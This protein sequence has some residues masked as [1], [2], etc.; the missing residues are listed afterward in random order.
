MILLQRQFEVHLFTITLLSRAHPPSAFDDMHTLINK[1]GSL[2]HR[3]V[4]KL[5]ADVQMVLLCLSAP[6]L[7]KLS[8]AS[9]LLFDQ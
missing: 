7:F 3:M 5:L 1:Y 6:N 9:P 2:S 4:C 8:Q